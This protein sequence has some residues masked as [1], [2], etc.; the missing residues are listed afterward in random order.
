M[1]WI[2]S[3]SRPGTSWR[4]WFWRHRR[5]SFGIFGSR[6]NHL[7]WSGCSWALWCRWFRSLWCCMAWSNWSSYFWTLWC[8]L[9]GSCC[10]IFLV[11]LWRCRPRAS[12]RSLLWTLW[13]SGSWTLW[14]GGFRCL[15]SCL[16]WCLLRIYRG[17][18]FRS[19]WSCLTIYRGTRLWRFRGTRLTCWLFLACYR[20]WSRS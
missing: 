11:F 18:W 12:W 19:Y 15:R 5:R 17:S 1:N 6:R 10:C 4:H 14:C 20:R 13:C 8:R 2:C 7:L 16:S 3:R 9:C